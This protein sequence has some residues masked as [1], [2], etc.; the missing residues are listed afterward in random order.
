VPNTPFAWIRA[1]SEHIGE[2]ASV[3]AAGRTLQR[4]VRESY[5]I[6]DEWARRI[7]A[8]WTGEI[9]EAP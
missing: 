1:I 6:D 3:R 4:A 7:F 8:T 5:T 9:P 2:F